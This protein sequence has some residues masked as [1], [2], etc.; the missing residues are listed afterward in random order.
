MSRER[1]SCWQVGISDGQV[2]SRDRSLCAP[3]GGQLHDS[4]IFK[5]VDL[6]PMAFLLKAS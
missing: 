1:A 5:Q 4:F 3:T 6:H 2:G